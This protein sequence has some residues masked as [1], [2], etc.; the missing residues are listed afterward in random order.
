MRLIESIISV[1]DTICM[2]IAGVGLMKLL[3]TLL[4][5]DIGI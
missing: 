1:G 3:F 4:G 5:V 2:S